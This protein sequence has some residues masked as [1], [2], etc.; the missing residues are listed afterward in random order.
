MLNQKVYQTLSSHKAFISVFW[1]KLVI[2]QFWSWDNDNVGEIIQSI[3]IPKLLR[4]VPD[5][6]K[7]EDTINLKLSEDDDIWG[8]TGLGKP[9]RLEIQ[10]NEGDG[11][12]LGKGEDIWLLNFIKHWYTLLETILKFG[13]L[14]IFC[15]ILFFVLLSLRALDYLSNI[16]TLWN[17]ALKLLAP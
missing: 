8:I 11:V 2:S 3:T 14:V 13:N 4:K 17:S 15:N 16:S 10:I 12:I 7:M 1:W 6:T 5:K 9:F